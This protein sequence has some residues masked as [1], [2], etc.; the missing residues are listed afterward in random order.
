MLEQ[1]GY[2]VLVAI[3]QSELIQ[4]CKQRRV[5]VAVI[6]HEHNPDTKRQF[7]ALV[8][9][10][11]PLAK[12]VEV[13]PVELGK[14]LKSADAWIALPKQEPTELVECIAAVLKRRAR[15]PRRSPTDRQSR[16][17]VAK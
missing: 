10:Y 3:T 14:T 13:Y 5:N 2:T 1:A 4:A 11:F 7:C 16:P 17:P 15:M 9:R 8:R 6:G 12:I